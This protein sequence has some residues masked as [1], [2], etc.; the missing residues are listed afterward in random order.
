MPSLIG[1]LGSQQRT[2]A[3]SGQVVK[4]ASAAGKYIVKIGNTPM[5][6]RSLTGGV[7]PSGARVLVTKSEGKYYVTA[8]AGIPNI[9][10]RKEVIID[11]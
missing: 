10:A 5:A 11:G 8:S 4:P 3:Y 6:L 2:R 7:I 1:V 9:A